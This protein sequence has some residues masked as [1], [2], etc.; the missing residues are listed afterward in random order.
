MRIW[1]V[2][3]RKDARVRFVAVS[4]VRCLE[5]V[6]C[7]VYDHHLIAGCVRWWCSTLS[8]ISDYNSVNLS[9]P[10][11]PPASQPSQASSTS[12][13]IIAYIQCWD[14]LLTMQTHSSTNRIAI[15]SA[16]AYVTSINVMWWYCWNISYRDIFLHNSGTGWS[17]LVSGD[18]SI[19]QSR[20]IQKSINI[21]CSAFAYW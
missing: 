2:L 4:R 21:R 10:R 5:A 9:S 3:C 1:V 6:H 8:A 17:W 16:A 19:P 15:S 14:L 13:V 18:Y 11:R 7:R 20:S 12:A